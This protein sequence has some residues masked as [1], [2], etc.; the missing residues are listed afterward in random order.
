MFIYY[1]SSVSCADVTVELNYSYVS[2]NFIVLWLLM[3]FMHLSV[4]LGMESG[5]FLA[6]NSVAHM[7]YSPPLTQHKI[8]L[9]E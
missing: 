6:R 1:S 5:L 3:V 8:I 7:D 2:A 9:C 4:E